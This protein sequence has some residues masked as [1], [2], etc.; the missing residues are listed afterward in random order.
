VIVLAVTAS[1]LVARSRLVEVPDLAGLTTDAA[2]RVVEAEGLLLEVAGTQVSVKVPEGCV[3]TQEPPAGTTLKR[4]MTV[5]VFVSAGPQTVTLP[6]LVGTPLDD[7]TA[8][9]QDLGLEVSVQ[10]VS[11]EITAT[12]VLEMYPAPG[13]LVSAG[14]VVRLTVPG[15]GA[16]SD[17]LLPYDFT[18]VAVVID[19]SPLRAADG[20]DVCMDVARRLQS[21]LVASGATVT[22]TRTAND[23]TSTP[24]ARSSVA[25]GSGAGVLVGIDL[26]R[27][28]VPGIRALYQ[29][30]VP[31]DP[32]RSEESVKLAQA[33]T[34]AA[35]LPG[36]VVNEP[37]ETTDVVAAGFRGVAVRVTVADRASESDRARMLDPAWADVVAR[38]IYRGLASHL[39][40][41]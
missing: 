7:A 33:I 31:G 22:F 25:N 6:D 3:V 17:V 11:S 2:R 30:A 35:R 36:F 13:A 8:Q 40:A 38:A 20:S 29:P 32:A 23:T 9:L 24:L 12:V 5:R 1:V 34:R 10:R 19:P 4:G 16:T 26:G 41:E 14:D 28:G 27:S 15:N 37:A 18:G 39:G 21:L